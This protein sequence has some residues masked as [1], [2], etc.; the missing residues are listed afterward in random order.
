MKALRHRWLACALGVSACFA[1]PG[2]P[3]AALAQAETPDAEIR[4]EE[5]AK[6]PGVQN[7]PELVI[8]AL[9]VYIKGFPCILRLLVKGPFFVPATTVFSTLADV[10][11]KLI[12]KAGGK[13]DGKTYSM[14]SATSRGGGG[15]VAGPGGVR[16]DGSWLQEADPFLPEGAQRS[17]LLDLSSLRNLD[18]DGVSLAQVPPGKYELQ[19]TLFQWRPDAQ[20][21]A[22][23]V[24][25]E[26]GIASAEESRYLTQVKALGQKSEDSDLRRGLAVRPDI[27]WAEVLAYAVPVDE[28]DAQEHRTVGQGTAVL[29]PAAIENPDLHRRAQGL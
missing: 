10:H 19:V 17:L 3:V 29:P 6:T 28:V 18:P 13:A 27:N 11:I 24:E 12:S 7:K 15:V 2:R 16:V 23:P 21:Q 9:P 26:L 5:R 22:Q 14:W 25:V 4:H 20:V 8:R 1:H